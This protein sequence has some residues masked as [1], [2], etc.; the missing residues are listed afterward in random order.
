[1]T[2]HGSTISLHK[3]PNFPVCKKKDSRKTRLWYPLSSHFLFFGL[4]NEGKRC[5]SSYFGWSLGGRGRRASTNPLTSLQKNTGKTG[6]SLV[7]YLI[8]PGKWPLCCPLIL[9]SLPALTGLLFRAGNSVLPSGGSLSYSQSPPPPRKAKAYCSISYLLLSHRES[10]LLS[11]PPTS[12]LPMPSDGQ[13][14]RE[15]GR[16]QDKLWVA[17]TSSFS[18]CT[19]K[20][21]R[22]KQRGRTTLLQVVR[23][24]GLPLP[25]LSSLGASADT[26]K[27]FGATA[28]FSSSFAPGV[29]PFLPPLPLRGK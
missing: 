19:R 14:R 10:P 7:L 4:K 2:F 8:L 24:V 26:R 27:D 29:P 22:R 20:G 6:S 25:P 21:G 16:T 13:L 9:I 28:K 12:P 11:L 3:V 18:S 5:T 23:S 1:M 17:H 15:S